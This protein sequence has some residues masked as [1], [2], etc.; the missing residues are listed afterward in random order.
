MTCNATTCIEDEK[1]TVGRS[2]DYLTEIHIDVDKLDSSFDVSIS[3]P[4]KLETSE[5]THLTLVKGGVEGGVDGFMIPLNITLKNGRMIAWYSIGRNL[6]DSNIIE[7]VY[8]TPC[9][10]A[11]RY[12]LDYQTESLESATID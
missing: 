1:T 11:I 8:G 7:A 6:S 12:K 5:L 10:A 3:F 9:G 4:S 2:N